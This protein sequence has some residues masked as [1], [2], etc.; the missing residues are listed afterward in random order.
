MALE[1]ERE[2]RANLDIFA[3]TLEKSGMGNSVLI[4]KGSSAC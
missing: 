1:W 3:Q 4:P 2:S